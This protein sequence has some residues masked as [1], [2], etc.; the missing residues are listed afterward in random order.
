M[1]PLVLLAACLL[2]TTNAPGQTAGR[3]GAF[4]RMGF[5]AR[6]IG[7]GNAMTAVT[8]GEVASYYNPAVPAFAPV[9]HAGASFGLLS[10][11]RSLNTVSF[12]QAIPPTGGL[13]VGL[14]NAGVGDIDGRDS[15]GEQTETYSTYENQAY[16]SF[17][18]RIAEQ[19]SVGVTMKL[20]HSKL[21]EGVTTTTVGFDAGIL[22]R[23]SDE[24][25]IGVLA[26]DIGSKYKW[27][28]KDVNSSGKE[29]EDKFPLLKRLGL[30]YV[31]GGQ[32]IVAAVDVEHAAGG[33]VV[34]RGGVEYAAVEH[35]TLRAGADR[36]EGGDDATG[37]KPA[38]GFTLA[39]ELDGWLPSL[40]YAYTHE[41]FA[42]RGYHMITL[43]AIF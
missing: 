37:V 7:M 21:F 2:V 35:F 39:R 41:G 14:I 17:S 3:A 1:N 10:L 24:L 9:R 20:Y 28:T 6:G 13:S 23:A 15:D 19:V 27:N 25:S 11:D 12:T 22:V 31:F 43:S 34:F 42:P 26:Q 16:L 5:G 4:A 36:I 30:A 29:T 18:N 38:F 40:S 8:T 32:G 33:P